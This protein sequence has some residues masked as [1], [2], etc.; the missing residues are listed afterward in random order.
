M[1][2]SIKIMSLLLRIVSKPLTCI[3]LALKSKDLFC[4]GMYN[5]WIRWIL[6][7]L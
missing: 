5:F 7:T 3:T 1:A 6:E 4:F 2:P